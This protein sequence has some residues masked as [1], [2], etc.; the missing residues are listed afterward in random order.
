MKQTVIINL[1]GGP[2]VGKSTLFSDIFSGL[3]KLHYEVE[4]V[5]EFAKELTWTKSFGILSDQLLVFAE[6]RHRTFRV[7]GQVD[8]IVT[9]SP[10]ILSHIYGEIY[11]PDMTQAFKDLIIEE[12]IRHPRFDVY[13]ERFHPYNTVGRNQTEK[14]AIDIDNRVKDLFKKCG[15]EFDMSIA[16]TGNVSEKIIQNIIKKFM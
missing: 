8:F 15:W 6:Q 2:G 13:L 3:K 1:H 5:P 12:F 16:P 4:M 14:Q 11:I 10:L 9:D 7:A